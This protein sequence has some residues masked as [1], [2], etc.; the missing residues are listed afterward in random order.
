MCAVRRRQPVSRLK[1]SDT[2]SGMAGTCEKDFALAH[3]N[4]ES[5]DFFRLRN[6]L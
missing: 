6:D 5:A 3:Q 1:D 2:L 4:A